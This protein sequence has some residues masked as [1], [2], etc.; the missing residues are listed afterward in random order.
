MDAAANV[1]RSKVA[2]EISTADSKVR[3]LVLPTNEELAM[4][5]ETLRVVALLQAE[6]TQGEAVYLPE[7]QAKNPGTVSHQRN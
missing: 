5:R 1:T 6:S 3:V 7:R 2:R 4:A